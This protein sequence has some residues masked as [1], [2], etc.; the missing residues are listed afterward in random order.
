MP[1]SQNESAPASRPAPLETRNSKLETPV[2]RR[3]LR[4]ARR[5]LTPAEQRAHAAAVSKRIAREPGL[6]R[7][8]R[9][10]LYLPADGEVDPLP[11]R[12]LLR[13]RERRWYLPV[14]RGHAPGH[15]WFV[16]WRAGDRLRPNRFGILEPVRRGRQILPAHALDLVLA[17]LV[18]FDADCHRIGMGGGFYDRTL[19]F[20]RRRRHW[21]R[22]LLVGL[23]HE[24]QYAEQIAPSDWDVPLDAVVTEDS[25]YRRRV[26]NNE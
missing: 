19:A 14:L 1:D 18:G 24:C 17:P 8:Q 12:A 5:A 26:S 23:A 21:R 11:L 16:R 25:I 4:R 6:R 10:A 15:L 22:P 2:L 20:L 3:R 13:G 7:A 9:I